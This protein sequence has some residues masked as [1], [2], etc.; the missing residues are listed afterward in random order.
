MMTPVGAVAGKRVADS[1]P[2][3]LHNHQNHHLAVEVVGAGR[4][5][6]NSKQDPVDEVDWDMVETGTAAVVVAAVEAIAEFAGMVVDQDSFDSTME[7]EVVVESDRKGPA[8]VAS[9]FWREHNVETETH[10]SVGQS[11]RTKNS[12]LTLEKLRLT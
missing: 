2:A 6:T 11:L 12:V 3:V 9:W 1:A 5:H 4:M 8:V 10:N 7:G